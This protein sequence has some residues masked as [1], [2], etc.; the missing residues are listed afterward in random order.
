M[1]P[2]TRREMLRR[3]GLAVAAGAATV[4][5]GSSLTPAFAASNTKL[6]A[7]SSDIDALESLLS[8]PGQP[9]AF[10]AERIYFGHGE[11]IADTSAT[12]D[13]NAALFSTWTKGRTPLVSTKGPWVSGDYL[14]WAA[15][16]AGSADAYFTQCANNIVN[17]SSGRPISISFFHEPEQWPQYGDHTAWISAYNRAVSQFRSVFDNAG[18][19]GAKFGSVLTAFTYK[20]GNGN[21]W[22][23]ADNKVDFLASDG[24]NWCS[25][26]GGPWT[27]F[28]DVFVDHRTFCINKNKGMQIWEFGCWETVSDPN[29]VAGHKGTWF[30]NASSTMLNWPEL[31]KA[32]YFNHGTSDGFLCDWFVDTTTGGGTPLSSLHGFR[33][34][35]DALA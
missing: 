21:L 6:G 11:V 31:K 30:E 35:M 14:S 29:Y 9:R 17:Q 7:A 3:S 23:P 18:Y 34:L 20:N 12:D 5:L 2:I 13:D 26:H 8:Q 27:S 19:T 33:D 24:Y 4:A 22:Y 28:H 10:S 16:A 15:I 1:D 32:C 25:A